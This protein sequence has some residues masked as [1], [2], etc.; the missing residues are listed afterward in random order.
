MR[1][2][3]FT[4]YSLRVLLYLSH[5]KGVPATI[6]EMAS[7]YKISRNHLVK[8][9]H[10]LGLIGFVK[11]TRGKNGGIRLAKDAERISI[12]DVIRVTEPDLNLLECFDP[13][14]DHC[15]ITT[16]CR[17]KGILFHAKSVFMAELDRHTLADIGNIGKLPVGESVVHNVHR[18]SIRGKKGLQTS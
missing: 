13:R 14:T 12:A 2:T 18:P 7:F 16:V 4:D 9:V 3:L 1:L 8:V 17:L 5:K 11:T 6:P 15:T 10:N